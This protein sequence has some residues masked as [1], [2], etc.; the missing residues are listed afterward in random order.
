MIM[1]SPELFDHTSFARENKK[2]LAPV[3]SKGNREHNIF[4][5]N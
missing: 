1:L 2:K 5:I 3:I 4:I